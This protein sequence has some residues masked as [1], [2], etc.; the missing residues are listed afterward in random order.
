MKPFQTLYSVKLY[1]NLTSGF[2]VIGT[3]LI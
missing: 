1:H 2:Q 3:F